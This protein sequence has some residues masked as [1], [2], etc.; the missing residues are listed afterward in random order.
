MY[1]YAHHLLTKQT[2]FPVTVAQ[3]IVTIQPAG[4]A[5]RSWRVRGAK[6]VYSKIFAP[7][8]LSFLLMP[9][10][11]IV[12]TTTPAAQV[13]QGLGLSQQRVAHWLGVAVS[14]AHVV[15]S[16]RKPLPL[17]LAEHLAVLTR[18]LPL[19]L[20]SGP[21]AALSTLPC[22]LPHNLPGFATGHPGVVRRSADLATLGKTRACP[23]KLNYRP[24]RYAGQRSPAHAPGGR[25]HARLGRVYA[26]QPSARACHPPHRRPDGHYDNGRS[27][28]G[29]P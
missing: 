19:P 12:A 10:P 17:A 26:H 11:R 16:G 27:G 5:D 4:L 20:G 3:Y 15:E 29:S 18:L 13:R 14:F 6:T 21:P 28:S 25:P 7:R 8:T 24:G 9:R 1:R 23:A 2:C 22:N